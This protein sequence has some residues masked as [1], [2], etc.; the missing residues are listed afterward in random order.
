MHGL[1]HERKAT[2]DR[3][4]DADPGLTT[5]S[6]VLDPIALAKH[7]RLFSLPPWNWGTA[8][9]VHVRI[10]RHKAGRRCTLELD[11]RTE[12]DLHS[13]I[14]KVYATDRADVFQTMER[15]RQAGFGPQDEFS[16]PQPLVYLPSLCLLVQEKVGGLRAKE[17]FRAGDERSCAAAAERCARWLA[18]FHAVAPKAGPLFDSNC[19]LSLMRRRSQR[20]GEL[21]RRFADKAARLLERLEDAASSLSPVEMCAGH[22]SYGGAHVIPAEGRTV[23]FD[24]DG[25]DLA[26]PARDVGRFLAALR[27]SALGGLGSIRALDAAAEVFLRT[28]LS[29]GQPQVKRNR[30]FYEAVGCLKLAKHSLCHD[31]LEKTEATLDEG[32]RVLEQEVTR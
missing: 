6:E 7:L 15:I 20:I 3:V 30:P 8:E 1:L 27:H 28:Y 16:I 9:E 17:I 13:M 25:Y 19:C 5:L 26:D 22:G 23:V 12:N 21:G 4:E 18:Q 11:L 24:W 32:I 2:R 14:G 29:L 10:L 31:R